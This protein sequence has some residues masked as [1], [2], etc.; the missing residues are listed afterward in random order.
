MNRDITYCVEDCENFDCDRNF[1]IANNKDEEYGALSFA[2]L[3]GTKQCPGYKQPTWMAQNDTR[4]S[5]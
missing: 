3:K 2:M 1:R 4:K 5:S